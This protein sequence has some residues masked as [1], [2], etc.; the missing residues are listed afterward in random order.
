MITSIYLFQVFLD[1]D[2][3]KKKSRNLGKIKLHWSNKKVNVTRIQS[4]LLSFLLYE[5][6][7]KQQFI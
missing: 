5:G 7:I 4:F 6:R 1:K 3:S 2:K